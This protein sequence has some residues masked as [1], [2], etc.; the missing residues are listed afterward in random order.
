L[1]DNDD[2]AKVLV[3]G[4]ELGSFTQ[5]SWT[6]K[7]HAF[8]RFG[9]ISQWTNVYDVEYYDANDNLVY[10]NTYTIVKK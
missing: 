2:I 8:E 10:S 5:P 7:Y 3:N 6:W 4:F 1:V 9:T